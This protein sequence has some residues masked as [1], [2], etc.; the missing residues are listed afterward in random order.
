MLQKAYSNECLSHTNVLEWYG[1]FRNGWES[2]DDDP[3]VEHPQ[4]SQTAKHMAKVRT[5]LVDDRRSEC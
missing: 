1:K 2:M 3:R 5:A 4:T